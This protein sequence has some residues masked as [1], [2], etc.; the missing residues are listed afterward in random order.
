MKFGIYLILAFSM[1][2]AA[3]SEEQVG[4]VDDD[5]VTETPKEEEEDDDNNNQND[6]TEQK[7]TLLDLIDREKNP[8]FKLSANI[9]AKDF[10]LYLQKKEPLYSILNDNFQE[11]VTGQAPQPKTVMDAEGNM[12]F[13]SLQKILK[14]VTGLG[15]TFY[16]Q[17]VCWYNNQEGD[18]LNSL[19][20]NVKTDEEKKEILLDALERWIKGLI[21]A[22]RENPDDPN[23]KLLVTSWRVINEAILD[24]GNLRTG[25]KQKYSDKFYWVDYLGRG[26]GKDVVKL[27]RKYGGDDIKLFVNDYN[28]EKGN[29]LDHL[30][31]LIEEWEEDPDVRIDGIGTQMHINYSLN[32][33]TQNNNEA[34]VVTMLNK[35]AAT[36]KLVRISEMDMGLK[37]E[38]GNPLTLKDLTP[39]IDEKMGEYY[40]FIVN[41]YFE[42]VP[43]AQRYGI[44]HFTFRDRYESEGG[45]KCGEP[46][47]LFDCNYQIK[48]TY[49]GFADGLKEG[50]ERE[51]GN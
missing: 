33:T 41:Q 27:V 25:N 51:W 10:D 46:V 21:N 22:C 30:I 23:S 29:K 35:M 5:K 34:G 20:E 40:K 28:L 43:P 44:C 15:K 36:G 8:D 49:K 47:G 17:T 39:E 24:N 42:I 13:D 32:P 38:N 1:L 6:D 16:V 48:A 19:I 45:W 18:Y 4:P 9:S 37:D 2:F 11:F 31:E 50:S 14:H 26:Y 7:E 12:N 3:C